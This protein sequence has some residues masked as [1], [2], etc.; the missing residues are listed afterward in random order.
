MQWIP[1]HSNTPGNDKADR[2]AKKGST[3]EQPI[4][5]TTLHTAKQILMTTNKEIYRNRWDMGRCLQ[6]WPTLIPMTTSTTLQ[7]EIRA[8]FLDSELKLI[9]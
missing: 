2:L 6:T 9:T 8:P 3:Q 4:T 1:G 7:E 5:A